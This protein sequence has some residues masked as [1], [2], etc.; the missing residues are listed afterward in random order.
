M[1]NNMNCPICKQPMRFQKGTQMN[2][3]DGVTADCVNMSCGMA[4]WGHGK[5]E[6]AAFEIFSQKCGKAVAAE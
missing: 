2:P 4:D 3:N 1:A 6:K 5:D